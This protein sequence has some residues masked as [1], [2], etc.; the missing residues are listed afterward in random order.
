MFPEGAVNVPELRVKL[1]L[2]VRDP[3]GGLN[4]P[5]LTEKLPLTVMFPVG[6]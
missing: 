3:E 5:V 4:V 6:P 1:P 2:M